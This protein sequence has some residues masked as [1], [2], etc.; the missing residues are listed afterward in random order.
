MH[1]SLGTPLLTVYNKLFYRGMNFT[2]DRMI[3]ATCSKDA[4]RVAQSL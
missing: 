4:F 3:M 1:L 2:E